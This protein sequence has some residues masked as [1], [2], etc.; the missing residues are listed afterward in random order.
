MIPGAMIEPVHPL[1]IEGFRRMTPAQKLSMTAALYEAGIQ[2][3]VAGL[4]MEH[5]DWPI[6]RLEH[7][8]RRSLLHAGT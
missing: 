1:Q 5:P 4:R 7:E 6:E 2:L 8:A 3:R